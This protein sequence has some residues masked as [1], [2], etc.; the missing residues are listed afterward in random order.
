MDR[1]GPRGIVGGHGTLDMCLLFANGRGAGVLVK[2]H[3]AKR[4]PLDGGVS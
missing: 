1:L 4:Q 3:C 2:D